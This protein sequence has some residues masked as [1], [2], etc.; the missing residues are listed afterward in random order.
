[1]PYYKKAK[2]E[3]LPSR[4]SFDKL[5][6]SGQ[7]MTTDDLQRDEAELK[8]LLISTLEHDESEDYKSGDYASAV[9]MSVFPASLAVTH[10][11]A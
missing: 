3:N 6:V 1:M 4:L 10:S 2:Q 9:S 11:T 8:I 7:I 5:I